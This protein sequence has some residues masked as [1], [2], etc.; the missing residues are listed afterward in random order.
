MKSILLMLILHFLSFS[1]ICI[2]YF[3][4]DFGLGIFLFCTKKKVKEEDKSVNWDKGGQN[5]LSPPCPVII[6]SFLL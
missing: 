6:K 1:F 2:I 5:N 3:C 4:L